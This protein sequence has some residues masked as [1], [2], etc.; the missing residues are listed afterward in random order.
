M[1]HKIPIL[2]SLLGIILGVFIAIIFG[3]NEDYFKNKIHKDLIGSEHVLRV[4]DNVR[5]EQ[6]I[7][8]EADKNWRYYQRF[9]FHSTGTSIM[10]LGI[11]LLLAF[12]HSPKRIK[13]LSAY[14]VSIGGFLYPFVWLFSAMYG[15][16]LTRE[17]AKEK[18]SVFGYMG[19]VFLVGVMI[20]FF[21]IARY[22]LKLSQN[23]E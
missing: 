14:F 6:Y 19:G 22:D 4:S 21:L 1:F 13:I 8:S 9:H 23:Q 18:F 17:V 16:S 2:I 11:L 15:P 3:V 20:V 10:S 7:K 5:R 12:S